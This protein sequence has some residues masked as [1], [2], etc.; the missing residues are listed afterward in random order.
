MSKGVLFIH[1]LL[2]FQIWCLEN[3]SH[4][5]P[6][7]FLNYFTCF[8]QKEN[9]LEQI[10]LIQLNVKTCCDMITTTITLVAS[11]QDDMN[12][13]FPHC[14]K[15]LPEHLDKRL[16][17]NFNLAPMHWAKSLDSCWIFAQENPMLPKQKVPTHTAN[18][19]VILY[20]PPVEFSSSPK[21][22]I[23]TSL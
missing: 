9:H 3:K 19:S 22:L 6:W 20:S 18:H 13:D 10:C 16:K 11:P 23:F 2:D 15:D 8:L 4:Y 17:S 14:T 5:A 21:S 12:S 1:L 7:F